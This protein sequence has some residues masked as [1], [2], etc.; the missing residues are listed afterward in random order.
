MEEIKTNVISPKE[1][2]EIERLKSKLGEKGYWDEI[3]NQELNQFSNNSE[4][5]GEVWFGE[6]VQSKVISY[7]NYQFSDKSINILD[8]GCGNCEF[9]I[10]LS[11]SEYINLYGIDYSEVS[12]KFAGI[13]LNSLELDGIKLHQAD[14]NNR[15]EL[16]KI[17]LDEKP[18]DIIHDKGTFDA[19][20]LLESNDHSNYVSNIIDIAG[21]ESTFIIT[22]CNNTK[23]ELLKYFNNEKIIFVSE[24]EHKKFV[25]GGKTG[26][27][28]TTL[29][30]KLN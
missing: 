1:N 18:F 6:Q 11:D 13:K 3:Y 26:Q 15:E 5:G 7:I 25:F 14:L 30:F 23:E 10:S 28:V 16:S 9:L 17:Y 29:I 21:K 20:M 2:V 24:I 8:L 27:T 22:S 19:F 4:L 12:L